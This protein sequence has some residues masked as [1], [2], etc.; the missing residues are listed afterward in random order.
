MIMG[1]GKTTV[2]A[3]L[4]ALMLADG[5]RLV[6][7]VVPQALL[8]FTRNVTRERFSAVVRKTT[9]SFVFDRFCTIDEALHRKLL[10][11][12]ESKAVLVCTS[13]SIKAFQLKFVELLHQLDQMH[14]N[15]QIALQ[16]AKGR[17]KEIRALQESFAADTVRLKDQL[18]LAVRILRLFRTSSLLLDEVDMILHPLKSEL[19]YPVGKKSVVPPSDPFA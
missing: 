14:T 13:T 19:N 11:A 5:K 15:T 4:L 10:K 8:D 16:Q 6:A 7:Q 1:A 3:P 9:M 17:K 2:V 18:E 12:V